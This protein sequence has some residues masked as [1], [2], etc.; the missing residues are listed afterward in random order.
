M[1]G[2]SFASARR[3]AAVIRRR[4]TSIRRPPATMR[5]MLAVA[6]PALTSSTR[7]LGLE[8]VGQHDRLG[9]AVDGCLKQFER[10][11]ALSLWGW[12]LGLGDV[13]SSAYEIAMCKS[14]EKEAPG[15]CDGQPSPTK[16]SWTTR[17]V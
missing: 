4:V 7:R 15:V 10:S 12:H 16:Y 3:P 17:E 1:N 14:M 6:N 9:A 13:V 8:P 11:T 2:L 5:T